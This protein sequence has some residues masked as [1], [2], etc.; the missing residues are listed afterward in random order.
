[1]D[2]V[3]IL[4]CKDRYNI[5]SIIFIISSWKKDI[6]DLGYSRHRKIS[7]Q[8]KILLPTKNNQIDFEFMESFIADLEAYLIVTGLK[9]YKLNIEEIE[10]LNNIDK[11]IWKE[12]K[13]GDL[14]ERV[15]KL[16]YKAKEL[17]KEPTDNYILPLL[18]SSFMNQGL[19][20]YAPKTNAT[21][22]K[23]VISIPYNSDVY[24]SYYQ[25]REFFVLSELMLLSGKIKI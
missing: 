16:Q 5:N 7:S 1:M 3:K 4:K 24:R 14:F 8:S 9:D 6:I 23:N 11:I 21:V 25:S 19:N 20:Y 18:T 22:L 15:K 10:A 13:M 12:Q 2:N 17:P